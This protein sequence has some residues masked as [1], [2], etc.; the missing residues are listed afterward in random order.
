MPLTDVTDGSR[1]I[2]ANGPRVKLVLSAAA[3]VGDTLGVSGTNT[4]VLADAL[5]TP[6]VPAKM[7]ALTGGASGDT[8]EAS[9][10]AVIDGLSGGVKGEP[11]Y[12]SDTAGGYTA[13]RSTTSP[14]LLGYQ[15]TAA[16]IVVNLVPPPGISERQNKSA[17]VSASATLAVAD[18]GVVQNVDTDVVVLTLPS[19]VVGHVFTVRNEA[20]D[21]VS[22][23][24][25]SPAALDYITGTG[26][27][28]VDNKDLIN[29]K[30]TSKRGDYVKLVAD[31]VNGFFIAEMVGIWAKEA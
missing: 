25:I 18:I 13:T 23:V 15:G 4:W 30:A 19:T 6:G 11:V 12:Q 24:A 26:L 21:G 20:L 7:V 3:K 22:G 14:Q 29:T 2:L 5:A 31:G 28:A 10:T 8:I 9:E 17:V 1:I 16:I 27:T